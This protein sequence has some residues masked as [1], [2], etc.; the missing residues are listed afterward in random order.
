MITKYRSFLFAMVGGMMA[1]ALLH[2]DGTLDL[3]FGYPRG[4]VIEGVLVAIAG[5]LAGCVFL[6]AFRKLRNLAGRDTK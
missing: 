3:G 6:L 1:A 4:G 5:S 2:N